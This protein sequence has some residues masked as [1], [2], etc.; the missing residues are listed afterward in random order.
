MG[1]IITIATRYFA[2]FIERSSIHVPLPTPSLISKRKVF[3]SDDEPRI[4][5]SVAF[6]NACY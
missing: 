1:I 5:S 4:L 2:I 6:V 3:F